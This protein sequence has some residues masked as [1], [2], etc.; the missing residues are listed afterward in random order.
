MSGFDRSKL[1][2]TSSAALDKQKREQEIKRPKGGGDRSFLTIEDGVNRIR[3]FPFHPD[4]SVPEEDQRYAE[5]K[6]VTFLDLER[7]KRDAQGKTIDGETEVRKVPIFNARVHGDL[8]MDLVEEYM[9]FAKETAIPNYT[10]SADEF[11]KVWSNIVGYKD[12]KGN[13]HS[14]LKPNDSWV[15]YAA[16]LTDGQ[17]KLGQ[18]DVKKTVK[19]Q[20]TEVALEVTGGE[21]PDPYTDPEDGYQIKISK[22]G[23][24]L[25]TK[26]K[27]SIDDK[28]INKVDSQK[29]IL[30]LTDEQLE[31][32]FKL[33]SLRKLF[34]KSYT[35]KDF[36]AQL[37]GLKRFDDQLAEK[38]MPIN[39]FS[40]DSFLDIIEAIDREL[41]EEVPSE[42]Q[43][44]TEPK[45]KRSPV[46]AAA[47]VSKP[48]IEEKRS[49]AGI[50]RSTI[51]TTKVEESPEEALFPE[52]PVIEESA[53]PASKNRLA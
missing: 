48:K 6:C 35:R 33:P 10:E 19:D 46:P 27:V 41:P 21:N 5:A 22:T 2:T 1:K 36:E 50:R 14:G 29:I 7:P 34:V 30:P 44:E 40:Y 24:G 4:D 9:K 23:S 25:D 3:I 12:G 16:K 18:L 53:K 26:Y 47:T 49:V 13:Y 17:W 51:Q 8:S 45:V 42:K 52:Q 39:V 37:E 32:W 28:M 20:L 11:K 43:P 38:K 15:M 31:E